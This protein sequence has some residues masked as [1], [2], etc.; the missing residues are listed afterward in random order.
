MN[1]IKSV[2][3]AAVVC[4]L[5]E[6]AATQADAPPSWRDELVASAASADW[7]NELSTWVR[8]HAYYPEQAAMNGEDGNVMI[9]VVAQPN[10]HVTSVEIVHRSGSRWL[11]MA[12][13]A[14]FRNANLPPLHTDEGIT[15][16]FTMHYFLGRQGQQRTPQ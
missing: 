5:A 16:N 6:C 4:L 12:T 3:I 14:L 1:V 7:R 9:Q 11:D 15:F 2:A 10:G 13:V 8:A